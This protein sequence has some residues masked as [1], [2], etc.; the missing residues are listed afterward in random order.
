ME[1]FPKELKILG[2]QVRTLRK[3]RN[4]SQTAL[5]ALIDMSNK[6]LDNVEKGRNWPSM[7]VYIALCRVLDLGVPPLLDP[8]EAQSLAR[9]TRERLN[10]IADKKPAK[11]RAQQPQEVPA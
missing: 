1:K 4:L 9:M 5:A 6:T 7:P 11:N 2:E 3:A 8:F 10:Q